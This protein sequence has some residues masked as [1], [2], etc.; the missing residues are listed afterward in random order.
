MITLLAH[1]EELLQRADGDYIGSPMYSVLAEHVVA[2]F[3]VVALVIGAWIVRR[4]APSRERFAKWIDQYRSL[5]VLERMLF[6]LLAI[7]GAVHAALIVSHEPSVYTVLYRVDAV[8]LGLVAHR[9]MVG[10][11][12]RLWAGLVLGGSILGY[13]ISGMSGEPPDQVGL[14]TKLVELAA[15]A[16]VLT[17]TSERRLRRVLASTSIVVLTVVVGIGAWAGAF[18]SGDGGHHL[19][20]TPEPGVLLPVGEDR[21]PTPQEIEEAEHI[22]HEVVEALA[23]YRDPEVAAAAGYKVDGMYGTS[24]HASNEAYQADDHIFDPPRP[25]TL[26]YAVG[27]NGPVLL[28]AMFE[29]GDLRLAGPAPGGPLTVWHAHDH[30]CF[31][32]TPPALAGL[33]S[34]FGGCPFGSIAI[35]M[36]GEMLHVW[37]LPGVEEPFGEIDEGWLTDYLAG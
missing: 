22:Y 35:P 37:T 9:L 8:A 2:I 11:S 18:Q 28:G 32:L 4:L 21:E 12:W 10:L 25:E 33:V 27:T 19:G 15:L 14:A 29:M 30:I 24:F 23:P 5:D 16:I 34:P 3:A 26:V 7:S 20:E 6:W 36:T 31:S 1:G 13:A 17:P